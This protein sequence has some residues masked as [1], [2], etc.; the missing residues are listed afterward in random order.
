M[1]AVY[2]LY[3]SIRKEMPETNHHVRRNILVDLDM[4]YLGMPVY[5]RPIPIFRLLDEVTQGSEKCDN[6]RPLEVLG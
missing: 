3:G 6:C 5:G 1:I 2:L 4:E